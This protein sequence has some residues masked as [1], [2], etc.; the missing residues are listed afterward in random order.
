MS[1]KKQLNS[2]EIDALSYEDGKLFH[3]SK[4]RVIE[5]PVAFA[6]LADTHGH[7]THF[8]RHKPSE[9]LARAALAGVELLGVPVDPVDD[10]ADPHML[11]EELS[12]WI[13]GA[14]PVIDRLLAAGVTLPST[15]GDDAYALLSRVR[16]WAGVH[17]Y[18]AAKL[19]EHDDL[20]DALLSLL[21]NPLCVGVGEF[22]LD[23]GP[24]N[25]CPADE[26]ERAF[27]WQLRLAHE[28]NLPVELHLRDPEPSSDNAH[29]EPLAHLHAAR[30]LEREGVPE[31]GC[32][33]HCYTSDAAV[34]QPFVDL[35]CMVAFGGAATFSRSDAI[36][37]AAL[38]C[39]SELLLSETDS[40]YMAPVPLRGQEC[41][42]AMVAFSAAMIA[43]TRA[44]AG[45]GRSETYEALWRNANHLFG[46]KQ[47]LH[48]R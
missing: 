16:I 25:R 45:I 7:L 30:I 15:T 13:D 28:R 17:P 47:V 40:P 18:G 29:P 42:P 23:Y 35:G 3:N 46:E 41:E 20:K 12:A 44:S 39:P 27:I 9:A 31:A 33:L 26:Q 22:G 11:T 10:A 8:K 43:D 38:A 34:M 4:G 36:R 24:Y 21:D 14:Y 37:D 32:D 6:P 2:T 48:T 1:T 5:L 19:N